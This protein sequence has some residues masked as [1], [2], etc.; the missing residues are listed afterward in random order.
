MPIPSSEVPSGRRKSAVEKRA[1]RPPT[2][3]KLIGLP[4]AG[5]VSQPA[6]DQSGRY[7]QEE[8]EGETAVERSPGQKLR[9]IQML[10]KDLDVINGKQN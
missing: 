9:H 8:D 5:Q 3:W 4:V 6:T 2:S 1:E 10:L 7:S